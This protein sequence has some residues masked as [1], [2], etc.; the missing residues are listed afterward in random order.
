M[1]KM[2]RGAT[3][4]PL[5]AAAQSGVKANA[6]FLDGTKEAAAVLTAQ[7]AQRRML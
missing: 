6:A 1:P 7:A 2:F 5:F 3:A 4:T